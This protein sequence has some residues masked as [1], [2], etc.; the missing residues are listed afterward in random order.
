MTINSGKTIFKKLIFYQ[1]VIA[2]LAGFLVPQTSV[3]A[4]EPLAISEIT[5]IKTD[6]NATI[7]WHT[8]RSAYGKVEYGLYS[9]DYNRSLQINQQNTSQTITIFGLFADTD[10]FFRITAWNEISEVISFEQSF[11]TDKETDNK[12]PTLSDVRV[13]H[14]TGGTA[15]VQWLTDENATSEID[16]GKTESYGSIRHD[17]HRV[18][19]HDLTITG[20]DPGALYHFRVKSKDADNNISRWH[21]MTFRTDPTSRGEHDPLIIYD[22]KPAS[23]NDINIGETTAI[24]T[25]RT[26]SLTEGWLHYGTS[27][28]YGKNIATNPPRKFVNSITLTNLN[29]GTTYYF[30]IEAR[31]VLGRRVKSEGGSFTTRST[32]SGLGGYPS[33]WGPILGASSCDINLNTDF[34]YFGLYYNLSEDHPDMETKKNKTSVARENDWYNPEYF[35][36]SQIDNDID[37]GTSFFPLKENKRG[38]PYHFAVNWR[39]I[40]EVPT[41]GFYH[42]SITSDDDSW[43]FIDDQLTTDLS[44]VRPARSQEKDVHLT[45]GYHKLEIYFAERQRRGST[46]SFVADSRLKFHPLPEGCSIEEIVNY[47]QLRSSGL[48]AGQAGIILGVSTDDGSPPPSPYVCNPNLGYTKIK[49]LYKTTDSP[50]IWAILETGQKH[51]ITSPT[52]FNK[53]QCNWRDVKTVSRATLNSYSN[54]TLVRTPT[55]PVIYH[56]FQRPEHKW[57]KINIPSPTIF[58]SYPNN[59]WGNVARVDILDIQAYPD[60]KLIKTADS[61]SAYLIEGTFKKLIKSEEVFERLGYDWAEVVELSQIHLDSFEDGAVVD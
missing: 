40:I 55:D 54:A 43:V 7:T 24:I 47:N 44:G 22:I 39:A 36:K 38:D 9:N 50:D 56:L 57:L 28:S 34:G 2:M 1:L 53:Y 26:N 5:V 23:E 52:A 46:F 31:D 21:D 33:D 4:D 35:S 48:L 10:Y 15:T 60:A 61:S 29:P 12:S 32:S 58:V 45:A 42:Y 30:E 8:N 13:V 19:V 49:A 16:Y 3:L 18:K 6:E 11:K 59:Y 41:D 37:F 17:G 14:N 25:W 51:Y 27:I 20:L